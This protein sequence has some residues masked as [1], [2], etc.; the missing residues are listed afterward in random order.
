MEITSLAIP[1]LLKIVPH[2]HSD[3]RGYFV[4]F[5][6]DVSMAQAGLT[7]RFI[8]DAA[9]V[10]REVGVLRGLHFQHAPFAQA[11]LV[12]VSRGRIRDIAVDV[13]KGSPWYGRW[14]SEEL[15]CDGG[16]M[17]WIPRGFLHG[18]LVLEAET[19]VVYKID[20]LY[21]PDKAV[22]VRFDDPDLAIDWGIPRHSLLISENDIS[23]IALKSFVPSVEFIE[24]R[25][26]PLA[27]G[28]QHLVSSP[29]SRV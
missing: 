5:W 25:L 21:N 13:R 8:Q 29:C 12:R 14:I 6:N 23:G 20:N 11:K 26:L 17:L 24:Q 10:S 1:D 3:A 22:T 2:R 19:E 27:P 16:E 4:E 28:A 15:T 9:S 7:P 18:F